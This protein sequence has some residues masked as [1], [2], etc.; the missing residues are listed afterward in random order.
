MSG[1]LARPF[2]SLVS[3]ASFARALDSSLIMGKNHCL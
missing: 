2:G 1:V 3:F